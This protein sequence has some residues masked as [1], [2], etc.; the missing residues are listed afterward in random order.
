[1]SH[2]VYNLYVYVKFS[3]AREFY[4]IGSFPLALAYLDIWVQGAQQQSILIFLFDILLF[5]QTYSTFCLSA[6]FQDA[7]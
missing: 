7:K 3:G 6:S 5:Q 4:I 1:M 2:L